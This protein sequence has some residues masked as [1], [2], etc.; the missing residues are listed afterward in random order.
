MNSFNR[1]LLFAI[2]ALACLQAQDISKGSISGVVR[3][4]SGAVIPGAVVKL[5][6]PYGDRNISQRLGG[7]R[8]LQPR[9]RTRLQPHRA[10]NRIRSRNGAK[11]IGGGYDPVLSRAG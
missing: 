4:A 5:T 8:L 7:I 3:D 11:F 6:S 9:G 2:L 10:A 1:M